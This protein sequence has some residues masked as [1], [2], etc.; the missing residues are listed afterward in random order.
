MA[1]K[2]NIDTEYGIPATYW[3]IARVDDSFHEE[4]TVVMQGYTS[5]SA[6]RRSAAPLAT[7]TL[8]IRGTEIPRSQ[9]YARVKA[10]AEFTG[11]ADV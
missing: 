7:M 9:I 10:Q 2:I 4:L 5:E 6:R 3:R 1:L 11:A 8:F